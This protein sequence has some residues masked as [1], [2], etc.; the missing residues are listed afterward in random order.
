MLGLLAAGGWGWP[1][2]SDSSSSG[3]RRCWSASASPMRARRFTPGASSSDRRRS[4]AAGHRPV[5]ALEAHRRHAARAGARWRRL[6]A[7]GASCRT[8]TGPPRSPLLEDIFVAVAILTISVGLI[9]P[10]MIAHAAVKVSR[11][12]DRLAKG[13]LADFSRAM[14]ALQ[15]GR[16]RRSARPRRFPARGGPL[17]RRGRRDGYQ[18]QYAAAG[19]G[20]GSHRTG[21]RPGGTTKRPQ[22]AAGD[23]REP[24]AAGRG[25]HRGPDAAA[26][27]L[28]HRVAE[29]TAALH[30]ANQAKSEFLANMSHE[31]R[32]PMNGVIGMTGLLLDTPLSPEQ[33]RLCDDHPDQRRRPDDRDQRCARLLQGRGRADDHRDRG[34]Q[35]PRPP[36]RKSS[37]SW[38]P[39]PTRRAWRSPAAS[40]R[41]FRRTSEG[42][43]GRLRQVL[44]NLVGNAIKFTENGEVA[45][46]VAQIA[47][48]A[49]HVTLR[50]SIRD[51]G[52]G[53]PADRQSAIFASFTQADNSTT[54]N[55]GGTGL[56]LT[57]SRPARGTHGRDHRSGERARTRQHLSD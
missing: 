49:T 28:E 38:R 57:I 39:P 15:R 27:T 6:P 30:A 40:H 16:P 44:T 1:P 36:W 11:A 53:I 55:Y 46:D 34:V 51:T 41:G 56:G 7:G 10:G 33:T 8:R 52:V 42:T 24:R 23:Q 47:A 50:L 43:C 32:T 54:R 29:R 35:S 4:G 18:L 13:T 22:G 25:A 31:I 3:C 37:I 26:Q 12:A 14:V 5:A 9:L 17:A 45:V 21:W 2:C 20:A 48:T 19:G